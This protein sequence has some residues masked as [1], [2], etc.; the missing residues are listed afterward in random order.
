MEKDKRIETDS[1]GP[2][3]VPNEFYYGAQ[4]A[5]SIL[6]FD[7]GSEKIPD[8]II[9]A[10]AII[11]KAASN[12]N[13]KKGGILTQTPPLLHAV[14]SDFGPSGPL[15]DRRA[16]LT[17]RANR[18]QRSSRPRQS[19]SLSSRSLTYVQEMSRKMV[20]SLCLLYGGCG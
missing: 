5:R 18:T 20:L 9:A 7:I 11:K 2:I 13:S 6:N 16:R 12:V 17:A 15:S 19:G 10:M 4:T 1:F 8:A 3:E 14:R